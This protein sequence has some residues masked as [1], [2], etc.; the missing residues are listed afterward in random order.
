MSLTLKGQRSGASPQGAIGERK[1]FAGASGTAAE[2]VIGASRAR[3]RTIAVVRIAFGV[4]WAVDAYL[5]WLPS[6]GRHTL[7]E[8]L[9]DAAAGDPTPLRSWADEVLRVVTADPGAFAVGMAI[10]ET[11]LA[12]A[13]L[14]GVLTNLAC[15]LGAVFALTV[16]AVG[17][18]FGGP[19]GPGSTDIGASVIYVLVFALLYSVNAGAV[20]GA[21]SWLRPRL[22]RLA[23]LA[24]RA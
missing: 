7:V 12:A 23:C 1:T 6:F 11:M 5:K 3:R 21:D 17:E 24:S 18:S 2:P 15:V 16:W 10:A 4:I 19:Y 13:L 8:K 20:W 22:G 9:S 14:I